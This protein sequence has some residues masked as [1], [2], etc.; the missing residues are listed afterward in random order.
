MWNCR[1][2]SACTAFFGLGFLVVTWNESRRCVNVIQV[3]ERKQEPQ[4]VVRTSYIHYS[5]SQSAIQRLSDVIKSPLFESVVQD[6]TSARVVDR[7]QSINEWKTSDDVTDVIR[8]LSDSGNL[9][10]GPHAS[11]YVRKTPQYM[12]VI[13]G[14]AKKQ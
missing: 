5:A 9:Q 4:T 14:I 8:R 13:K 6:G 7:Q 3:A 2:A 10:Y 1:M 11:L 12:E